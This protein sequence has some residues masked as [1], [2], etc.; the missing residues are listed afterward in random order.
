[1]ANGDLAASIGIPTVAGTADKRLGYDEI[2]RALDV[3]AAHLISGTHPASSISSG[4]LDVARIP[5]LDGTKITT[6]V[7]PLAGALAAGGVTLSPYT[8]PGQFTASGGLG[9]LGA[10]ASVGAGNIGGPLV[11]AYGRSNGG[12]GGLTAYFMP[13]GRLGIS[14]SSRRFKKQI[15]GW[16][17]DLQAVLAMELVEFHWKVDHWDGPER[18]SPA[19]QGLIAEQL[20]DLGLEWLIFRDDEGLPAGVRYDRIGLA[21]LP[22]VQ[23]HERRIAALE[24]AR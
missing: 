23:D 12:S 13:D 14:S 8:I 2:N 7:V 24:E 19:D 3:I 5:N 21:L 17:P 6:G 9:V 10:F 4:T 15:K 11:N 16:S 1:M 22:V 20:A 18:E